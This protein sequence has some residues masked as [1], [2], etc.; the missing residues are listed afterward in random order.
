[1]AELPQLESMTV[2]ER[3]KL[4]QD[5]WDDIAATPADVPVTEAQRAELDHRLADH[6]Q[7]SGQSADWS[8]VKQRL[9]R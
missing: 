8:A 7:N 9:K 4:V 2:A 1:M 3:I 5:L 6:R